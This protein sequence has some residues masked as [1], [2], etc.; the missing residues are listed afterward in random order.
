MVNGGGRTIAQIAVGQMTPTCR[1]GPTPFTDRQELDA[2]LVEFI[3][4]VTLPT[5]NNTAPT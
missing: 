3:T 1:T 5:C 4:T 2:A